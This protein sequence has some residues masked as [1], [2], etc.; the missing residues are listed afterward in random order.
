MN[1]LRTFGSADALAHADIRN[2]RKCFETN[3]RG[4]PDC[5]ETGKTERS[6]YGI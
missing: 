6:S 5:T 1:V 4:I 3:G 2:I